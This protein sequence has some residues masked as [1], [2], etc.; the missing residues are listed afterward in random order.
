MLKMNKKI[1]CTF[2]VI[3]PTFANADLV[4]LDDAVLSN[5]TGEGLGIV[6]EDFVFNVDDAVTTVTGIKSSSSDGGITDGRDVTVDWTEFYVMG[7]GSQNGTVETPGQIGS[8]AHPWVLETLPGS[9]FASI[10]DDIALL[11]LRSGEYTY[12]LEN[13]D[14][15]AKWARY[16]EC[17]YGQVGCTNA[18][19]AVTAIESIVSRLTSEKNTLEGFYNG[20]MVSLE[21]GI[22][23]DI[24]AQIT[25]QQQVVTT[26]QSQI[27][28][29]YN[30]MEAAWTASGEG[31]VL[32][33]KYENCG[34]FGTSECTTG[35]KGTYNDRVDDYLA[36]VDD[37]N[38]AE[39]ELARR[40]QETL[41]SNGNSLIK[42][43]RDYESYRS[44]CGD[45]EASNS[46][47]NGLVAI[48]EGD[49]EDVNN[50][51][52]Q[53]SAGYSRRAGLDIGSKFK[54]TV[55][56]EDK[57]AYRED[58]MDIDMKGVTLDGSYMK[59]WSRDNELNAEF[60]LNLYAKEVNIGTCG[61]ACNTQAL[62]DSATLF[63][64]NFY[65]SLSL[66][67]G[68]VQPLKFSVTADGNFQLELSGVDSTNYE[69]FYDNAQKSYLYVGN[70]QLG[71]ATA[72]ANSL[73]S[74]TVDGLRA[75]YL[76]VTSH[77]L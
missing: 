23:S 21:N 34:L 19:D 30:S 50:V 46:C 28:P 56:D 66:G 27:A 7:E 47:A 41:D 54:F 6:L 26:E 2:L 1:L 13:T 68:E 20:Q 8:L 55:Y 31:V 73:G 32:G 35:T 33:Q 11:Q 10:G 9:A 60:R 45:V 67:Y 43:L 16:Q 74:L 65:L 40:Y 70:I 48:R 12:A 75:T 51:A 38:V 39:R 52:V 64:D 62:Q 5:A 42:R 44:L 17:V 58:F 49:R 14:K 53:L 57:G 69:D 18:N 25:P 77:D 71:N 61:S 24:A 22:N 29:A 3:A 72:A 36:E 37:Y 4:A 63:M 15:Y 76:K 59:L